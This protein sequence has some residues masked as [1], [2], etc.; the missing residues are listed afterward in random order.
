MAA[1]SFDKNSLG[2]QLQQLA[3]RVGEWIEARFP[4]NSPNLPQ[5][6]NWSFPTWL[7][8]AMFWA[9]VLSATLWLSWQLVRLLAPYWAGS[10]AQDAK[11]QLHKSASKEEERSV[12]GWIRQ[13]QEFQRQ[14]NYRE[15]C[16]ALYMAMLQRLNDTK[17]VP[18]QFSRTDGEYLQVVQPLPQSQA[19]QTLIRTH[20]QL[21][22]GDGVISAD[23]FNRCQRAYQ[24][25]E[26]LKSEEV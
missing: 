6:P 19:Y 14:G 18:H 22:F 25:I 15:A 13:M 21:C 26:R 1:D 24:E 10:S 4:Q 16:R 11:W 20:E 5:I 2:W 12:A 7:L 9:I 17:L 3:Q 8:E 23:V